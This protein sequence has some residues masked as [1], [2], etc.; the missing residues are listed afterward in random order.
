MIWLH[1]LS[2][3]KI[4]FLVEMICHENA[5]NVFELFGDNEEN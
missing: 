1:W 2:K 5:Y 4:L 3:K